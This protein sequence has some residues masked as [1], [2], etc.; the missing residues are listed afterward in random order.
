MPSSLRGA[1]EAFVGAVT[2]ALSAKEDTA[3]SAA[4]KVQAARENLTAASLA[5]S[6]QLRD[7]EQ[8]LHI[9]QISSNK[10]P[11]PSTQQQ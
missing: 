2:E 3:A 1:W 7:A 6:F 10:T 8:F 9:N 5:A 4:A 11:T